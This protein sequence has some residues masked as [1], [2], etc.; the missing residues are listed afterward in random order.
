MDPHDPEPQPHAPSPSLWPVGFAV[1]I[2]V[3]LAGVVVGWLVAAI[4]AALA[5]L[6]GF[7]WARDVTG[8]AAPRAPDEGPP[9]PVGAARAVGDGP[10]LALAD[11]A[12]IERFPRSRFLEGA[13]LG[14]GALI[15]GLITV[16]V[17]GFAIVPPFI[18]QGQKDVDIGPLDAFSEG[19]WYVVTFMEDPNEGEVTRRTAFVRYNGALKGQPSF[20]I[21]SN[22]CAHLGCPVQ[23]AGPLQEANKKTVKTSNT[24]VTRIPVNPAA[25][26]CPCHGGAYDIEG[27][28]TAGPPVRALDRYAYEIR[29]GRIFLVHT[30]SVGKVEGKGKDAIII[31]YDTVNPGIHVDGPEQILYPISPPQ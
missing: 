23:P 3:L 19:Q 24:T 12:E 26:A 5:L 22:R 31:K 14:L 9:P 13:T 7:L 6:F 25:F 8:R 15:G 17:A 2:A 28:R 4:G 1:G 20:T 29:N 21:I 16:P 10:A 27:N 18:G 11:E 30:Y